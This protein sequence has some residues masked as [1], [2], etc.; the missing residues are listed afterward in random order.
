[1]LMFRLSALNQNKDFPALLGTRRRIPSSAQMFVEAIAE[2]GS[3]LKPDYR[4]RLADAIADRYE[5]ETDAFLSAWLKV[6]PAV[7][8][9][10]AVRLAVSLT[11][12]T[13]PEY[14]VI[15]LLSIEKHA[16]ELKKVFAEEALPIINSYPDALLRFLLFPDVGELWAYERELPPEIR[17]LL[18]TLRS[19]KDGKWHVMTMLRL[20]IEDL[21]TYA[22]TA[23]ETLLADPLLGCLTAD[24]NGSADLNDVMRTLLRKEAKNIRAGEPVLKLIERAE[25]QISLPRC[26][27]SL[28]VLGFFMREI[29]YFDGIRR[30]VSSCEYDWIAKHAEEL[31][32]RMKTAGIEPADL[33]AVGLPFGALLTYEAGRN[34]SRRKDP[35]AGLPLSSETAKFLEEIGMAAKV[36]EVWQ[37]PSEDM[38]GDIVQ[39]VCAGR[40]SPVFLPL[41]PSN[42]WRRGI[43]RHVGLPE[44][45]PW[46]QLP[47]ETVYAFLDIIPGDSAKTTRDAV[48]A[49]GG[50][51]TLKHADT[52]PKAAEWAY[53]RALSMAQTRDEALS[54]MGTAEWLAVGG[55]KL[56]REYSV[57]DASGHGHTRAD[58]IRDAVSSFERSRTH[59]DRAVKA[60]LLLEALPSADGSWQLTSLVPCIDHAIREGLLSKDEVDA[61]MKTCD[62]LDEDDDDEWEDLQDWI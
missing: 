6:W 7:T 16:P 9:E 31:S 8:P 3:P 2:A 51:R 39:A 53:R 24:T 22:D 27:K 25:K 56:H 40:A 28:H 61:V 30:M 42:R 46:V 18:L 62:F 17:T 33:D 32:L 60:K 55:K 21:N 43:C 59:E 4:N 48:R 10:Q 1:M 35:E 13:A 50:K 11:V 45:T 47:L 23:A 37:R 41:L 58:F 49:S 12:R 38:V 5:A 52:C 44:T 36:I 19:V 34:V 57:T 26:R 54:L 14:A 29:W 15:L 20:L